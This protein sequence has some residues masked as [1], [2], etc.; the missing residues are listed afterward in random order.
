MILMQVILMI[1][2]VAH[3]MSCMLRMVVDEAQK[4]TVKIQALQD[5][6]TELLEILQQ[7]N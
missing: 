3:M 4:L 6:I 7:T 1:T 2:F 5:T